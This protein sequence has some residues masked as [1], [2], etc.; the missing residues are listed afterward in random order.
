MSTLGIDYS[1]IGDPSVKSG[2]R[3]KGRSKRGRRQLWLP[4]RVVWWA[5]LAVVLAVLPFL[6][7]IRG[8]VFAHHHWGLAPWLALAISATATTLLLA[9][10][11]L[12][13]SRRIGAGKGL[14]RA[15][16]RAATLLAGAY[17]VYSV[18]F[19]AGGNVKSGE[20][21][22]E[23]TAL[24]PLLRL[25]AS[26]LILA[27]PAAVITDA[28][29]TPDFY[30]RMGLSPNESSLHFEQESGFVHALDLRTIGR[31]EWRN[32]AAEIAFRAMGFHS[33]RHVGTADH[34]H[35]SLRLPR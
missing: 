16:T 7:L 1:E 12:R 28:G 22:A 26:A 8:G 19:V 11:A 35:V 13:A 33:L 32:R 3:S 27:D 17:V 10:Y 6:L 15:M 4:V 23:Y 21:R 18:M 25:G 24:H 20:V 34:L 29:R 31:P 14:T 30:R 2:A 5:V 9:L